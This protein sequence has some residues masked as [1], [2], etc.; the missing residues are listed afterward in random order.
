MKRAAMPNYFKQIKNFLYSKMIRRLN[1][2]LPSSSPPL[3]QRTRPLEIKRNVANANISFP[4]LKQKEI[5]LEFK[6]TFILTTLLYYYK[7]R[8][9]LFFC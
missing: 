7:T 2:F 5:T 1:K 4:S 3:P 9:V 8:E 6:K